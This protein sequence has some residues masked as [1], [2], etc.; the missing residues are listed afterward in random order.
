MLLTELSKQECHE[1][2]ARLGYGR[3]ACARDNQP[4]IVP[5][6]FACEGD[7][8]YGFGTM[9]KKIEWMRANPRVC[10]E[11]DEVN[12]HNDWSSVVIQGRYQELPETPE[13]ASLRLHAQA[14]L[15]KRHLW[16]QTGFAAAQTRVKFDRDIPV[17]YCVHIEEISGHRAAADPVEASF[18]HVHD[19]RGTWI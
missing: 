19:G 4:Y 1:L 10:V 8:I 12:S 11:A 7:R 15:E 6:Y 14:A 9:G 2:I 3:L 17:F 16:W 13:F 5:V 18:K